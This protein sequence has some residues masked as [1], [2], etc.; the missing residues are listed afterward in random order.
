MLALRREKVSSCNTA[1]IEMTRNV[2]YKFLFKIESRSR[3]KIEILCHSIYI[4][5][6]RMIEHKKLLS[7]KTNDVLNIYDQHELVC[8]I[9]KHFKSHINSQSI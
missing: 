1:K 2:N 4:A 5:S 6:D 8:V 7:D 3:L 9:A